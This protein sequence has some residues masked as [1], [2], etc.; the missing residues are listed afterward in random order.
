MPKVDDYAALAPFD[1]KELVEAANAVLRDAPELRVQ[2]RTVRYYISKGL[3]A[4]PQGPPKKARYGLD[5]L[6]RLETIRRTLGE[7]GS[8]ATMK[9]PE[10]APRHERVRERRPPRYGAPHQGVGQAVMRV[11]LPGGSVLETPA[12]EDLAR[13]VARAIEDLEGL[14][15]DMNNTS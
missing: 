7:E 8:L 3:L 9:D 6:R 12:G 1:M 2:E 14:L 15:S 4:P 5:H 11:A 10:E 13:S